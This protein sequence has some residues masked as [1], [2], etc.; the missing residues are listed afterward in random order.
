MHVITSVYP[1]CH[2]WVYHTNQEMVQSRK[3]TECWKHI[4]CYQKTL[5]IN[6]HSLFYILLAGQCLVSVRCFIF[7]FCFFLMVE[8]RFS[9]TIM[10]MIFIYTNIRFVWCKVLVVNSVFCFLFCVSEIW[11]NDNLEGFLGWNEQYVTT[12]YKHSA[13]QK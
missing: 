8:L 9:P 4:W 7:V 5:R 13:A 10:I 2:L 1:L 3:A 12:G 11:P 6:G